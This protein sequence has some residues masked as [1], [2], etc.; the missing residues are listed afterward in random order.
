MS[1]RAHRGV[2]QTVSPRLPL[3]LPLWVLTL[4]ASPMAHSAARSKTLSPSVAA[5]GLVYG[6]IGTSPLYVFREC[7]AHG[8]SN[9]QE[10]VGVLSLIIWTI[11]TVVSL[12]YI[13]H[14]ICA[15]NQG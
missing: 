7:L 10:I 2:P 3:V 6:D 1:K 15:N 8:V 9:N 4:A 12:K 5:L 14:I 13:R 11:F